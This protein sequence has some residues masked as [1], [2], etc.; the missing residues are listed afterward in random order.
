M[1]TGTPR[2]VAQWGKETD[3]ES[4]EEEESEGPLHYSRGTEGWEIG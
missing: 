3:D 4:T 1:E 2:N